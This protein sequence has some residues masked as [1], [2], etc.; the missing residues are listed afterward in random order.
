MKN[1]SP[2]KKNKDQKN[3]NIKSIDDDNDDKSEEERE[4]KT[5]ISESLKVLK[6]Y[7]EERVRKE[8][9][10]RRKKA[11]EDT[12]QKALK[13]KISESLKVLKFSVEERV[14][15]EEERELKTK[16]SESLKVL[17]F[18]VE[19]RVPLQRRRINYE[20]PTNSK[21]IRPVAAPYNTG[22]HTSVS[23]SLSFSN[24]KTVSS[25]TTRNPRDRKE[26]T[27]ERVRKKEERK[28]IEAET[29]ERVRKEKE[30][31]VRKEEETEQLKTKISESLKVLKF[32]V[33]EIVKIEEER[34]RRVDER[35]R[36]EEDQRVRREEERVRR[37][38]EERVSLPRRRISYNETPTNAK[39]IRP[40]AP[41]YTTGSGSL[42]FSNFKAVSSRTTRKLRHRKEETEQFKTK[43]SESL[44]VLKFSV[45]EIVK[46]EAERV[47]RVKEERELKTNISNSLKVLKFSVEERVKI[48]EDKNE[49]SNY[50]IEMFSNES[51]NL[52]VENNKGIYFPTMEDNQTYNFFKKNVLNSYYDNP[53]P[54]EA[55][56][57]V[58]DY[59]DPSLKFFFKDRN[60]FTDKS[61]L[62]NT[63]K[64]YF[65]K[66]DFKK[67]EERLIKE[68]DDNFHNEVFRGKRPM[69]RSESVDKVKTLL[70]TGGKHRRRSEQLKRRSGKQPY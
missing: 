27:A 48:E 11:E 31:R 43:I 37:E 57:I 67:E 21:L 26:E 39:L 8:E 56:M 60:K 28:K 38:E 40:V 25:R 30:E 10:E 9:E 64:I 14:R 6:F 36:R 19:E 54:Y 3:E 42:R 50:L 65:E 15:K 16:I 24:S 13:T 2:K 51:L 55:F 70:V 61:D 63:I 46:I 20:T 23:G 66:L 69:R 7:V 35:V 68:E 49:F 58:L 47:D 62:E 12:R 59:I 41:P 22:S 33:E 17:K 53:D 44:K 5:K 4:L 45:E 52:W 34:V 1:I 29:A 18:S 32:S